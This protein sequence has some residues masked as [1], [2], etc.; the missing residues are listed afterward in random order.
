MHFVTDDGRGIKREPTSENI[1]AEI[2]KSGTPCVSWRIIDPSEIPNDRAF[3]DAWKDTGKMEVDM[4]R[5]R[6]I[7]MARIRKARDAKLAATD[8]EMTRALEAGLDIKQLSAKRQAL[9]DIPQTFDLSTAETPEQLKALWPAT[10][11]L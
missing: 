1:N 6:D 3:R 10:S 8:I 9:R 7:H 11:V 4:P 5:A 2:K